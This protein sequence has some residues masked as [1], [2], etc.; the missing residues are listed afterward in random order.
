MIMS[1][2]SRG[3]LSKIK[4]ENLNVCFGRT[5]ILDKVNLQINSG[6]LIALI[7][8][9]GAGK[10]TLLKSILGEVVHDGTISFI[11]K[12]NSLLKRSIVGYVPQKLDFDISS[13][14]S[15]LDVFSSV[16]C[17]RPICFSV[18]KKIRQ[19]VKEILAVVNSEELIDKKL[20]V[21]SGGELQRVLLA[22]AI[23]PMPDILL[24]DEPVSGIDK[25][26][27]EVFYNIVLK[28]KSKYKLPILLI[29]HDLK[30]LLNYADKVAFLNNNTIEALGSP[31]E[32][33][34]NSKVINVFGRITKGDES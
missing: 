2:E 26:G 25:N 24:L 27:L 32:V 9:N 12:N 33:F 8:Q 1:L 6:E 4:I 28:L 15:V 31:L 16:L 18:S 14:V 19:R 23:Y 7:G 21:L 13:P 34:N 3:Q 17:K 22:L 5:K 29:T 11:A 10:S 30:V 20:G